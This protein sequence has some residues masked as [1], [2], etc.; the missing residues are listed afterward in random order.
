[1][2]INKFELYKISLTFSIINIKVKQTWWH[3]YL[4][5]NTKYDFDRQIWKA[6]PVVVKK[7]LDAGIFYHGISA[8]LLFKCTT[9]LHQT[10]AAVFISF[11]ITKPL[12]LVIQIRKRKSAVWG[13]DIVR[14][15]MILC[16][17]H[18]LS[19]LVF[20]HSQ[21]FRQKNLTDFSS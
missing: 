20:A 13:L 17:Y 21:V 12:G 5:S 16:V 14:I 7:R 19:L 15:C 10:T 6:Y 2:G 4:L 9:I 18:P 3:P 11:H 1:M 8:A